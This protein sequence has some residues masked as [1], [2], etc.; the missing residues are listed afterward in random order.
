MNNSFDMNVTHT[1][2]PYR[3]QD[4]EV[5][6][7]EKE[8]SSQYCKGFFDALRVV[9]SSNK[10]EFNGVTS[11]V[12]PNNLSTTAFSPITPATASDMH[13]IV[14]SIL[15]TPITGAPAIQPLS[16]PTLLPL[17]T[18]GDLQMDDLSM[19]LLASSAIPGPPIVSSSNSPDSSTTA[20]NTSQ[21]TTLPPLLNNFV[22]STTASTSRPDKLNLTPPQ[23]EMSIANYSD[24]SDGGFDSRSVSR[25][26]GSNRDGKT[27]SHSVSSFTIFKI[28]MCKIVKKGLRDSFIIHIFL[29]VFQSKG[30][31][32]A[33]HLHM[34]SHSILYF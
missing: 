15:G 5:E 1:N 23:S 18:S 29:L 14:M 19:K 3:R 30:I 21:I 16:S 4:M 17:V 24:D 8:S 10:F 32:A 26:G 2:S 34:F 12:L 28:F 7:G 31:L 13:T 11:P 22:S 25:A 27:T 20:V 33:N 6:D 9:Q